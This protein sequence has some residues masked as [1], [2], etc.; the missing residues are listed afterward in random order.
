MAG[1]VDT[2]LRWFRP[3]EPFP[4]GFNRRFIR[5]FHKTDTMAGLVE[6]VEDLR[7]TLTSVIKDVAVMQQMLRERGLWD[8]QRYCQ[9]RYE[10][11]IADH[12]SAGASP[13]ASHSYYRYTLDE[14]EFIREALGGGAEHIAEFE[15]RVRHVEQLT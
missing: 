12:S 10:R 9:L 3:A 11:M 6:Q 15:R 7:E 5:I 14:P 4:A 8:E 13:W 1:M 2:V